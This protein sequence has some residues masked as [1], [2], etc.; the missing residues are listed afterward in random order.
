M[1]DALI[2]L[3]H[4]L[5]LLSHHSIRRGKAESVVLPLST[6][7]FLHPS[8]SHFPSYSKAQ[9]S[10]LGNASQCW[11]SALYGD[12]EKKKPFSS[13]TSDILKKG[14]C[15]NRHKM[16]LPLILHPQNFSLVLS[17][18]QTFDYLHKI[19][20]ANFGQEPPTYTG[21]RHLTR[22]C[23]FVLCIRNGTQLCKPGYRYRFHDTILIRKLLGVIQI[24]IRFHFWLY[25]LI[26]W[27]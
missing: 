1:D 18:S 4:P 5:I 14:M 15:K 23:V 7:P 12:H 25:H 20:S 19:L 24:L 2:P 27:F 3:W 9:R 26:F 16:P 13:Q 10:H 21:R 17:Q 8:F 22:L 11:G 6:I